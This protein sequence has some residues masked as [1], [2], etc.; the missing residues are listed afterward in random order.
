MKKDRCDRPSVID[1]GV[2]IITKDILLP[3]DE[4]TY[5]CKEGYEL[6]GREKR[7]CLRTGNWSEEQPECLGIYYNYDHELYIIYT[8][9]LP[10]N[11][12]LLLFMRKAVVSKT[13]LKISIDKFTFTSQFHFFY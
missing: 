7:Y 12:S 13:V 2:V 11:I 1:N 8:V 6:S 3:G 4:I 9:S 10:K 5:T